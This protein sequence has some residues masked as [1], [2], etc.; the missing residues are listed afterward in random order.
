MKWSFPHP[1]NGG[2][3]ALASMIFFRFSLASFE[4]S[5]TPWPFACVS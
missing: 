2:W 4:V 3:I 5:F 1:L